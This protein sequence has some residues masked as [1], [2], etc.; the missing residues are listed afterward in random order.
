MAEK[1]SFRALALS[2]ASNVDQVTM[3]LDSSGKCARTYQTGTPT[4]SEFPR[5][6]CFVQ[7]SSGH[8]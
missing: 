5:T 7:P 2:H 3:N 6:A 1:Q 8:H 4:E